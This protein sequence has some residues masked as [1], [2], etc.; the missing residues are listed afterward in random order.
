[1]RLERLELK[2]FMRFGAAVSLDL[3]DVPTGVIAVT[4][5]NGAGK[6]TILDSG[7]AAPFLAFPSRE[8]GLADYAT[9]RDAYLDVLYSVEG[10]GVYR[11]RVNVD[12]MKRAS[13]AVLELVHPDGTRTPLNDGKV[14]T[15]REK[16][17]EIFPPK[18]LLLAS[19]FAA[20]N[21]AGSFVTLDKKGRKDLFAALLGLKHYEQ[22]ADT[23]K[24]CVQVV[25][26][27]RLQLQTERDLLARDTTP[28][29]Q[30]DLHVRANA[31]QGEGGQAELRRDELRTLIDRLTSER[32]VLVDQAQAHLAALE[33]VQAL[34]KA[35]GLHKTELE[36]IERDQERARQDAASESGRA[37]GHRDATL[38]D[39]TRRESSELARHGAAVSDLDQRLAG[40]RTLLGRADEIRKAAAT[41]AEAQVAIQS[42]RERE[43]LARA[44]ETAARDQVQFRERKLREIE[45]AEH[46]LARARRQ[47]ETLRTVP[48]GG[49]GEY[50]AC[51]FLTDTQAAQARIPELEG[52]VATASTLRDGV[53][54]WNARIDD[55]HTRIRMA[56]S[57]IADQEQLIAAH[58]PNAKYAAHIDAAEARIAEYEQAKTAAEADLQARLRDLEAERKQAQQRYLDITRDIDARLEARIAALIDRHGRVRRAM[59]EAEADLVEAK[60][61]DQATRQAA[62]RLLA[63]DAELAQARHDWTANESVLAAVAA[64]RTELEREREAFA[65][66]ARH[67]SDVQ[68][69]LRVLDDELLAWQL[70]TKAFG[71]DGLPTLEID[72]AGPTVSNLTNDLLSACFG[73]RFTVDLVT[74]EARADGKGLKEIFSIFVFDN[75]FGG[76]QRDIA[77]LSGGE[78]VIV[79][80]ALRAALALFVNSRN[81]MPIRTL[82]R[83]E[84]VGALDPENA[85]RYVS[86]LR[87]LQDLGGYAHILFISHNL[88]A[89]ALADT[90]IRVHDGQLDVVRRAA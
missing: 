70:L 79:E 6:T 8:G 10:R 9:E 37:E 66:K 12:G 17:A 32:D 15:F 88:D 41:V 50:A 30:H 3:R 33:R 11:A 1:M 36:Q 2:G 14:T 75:Q 4:G 84:T 74:Q 25:E 83:D 90:E 81:E 29:I 26:S 63:I 34:A 16:V 65:R 73:P 27:G 48:C 80:E 40:N 55:A 23:A 5:E 13:D 64:K 20:Q 42:L 78:R 54:H 86:M 53:A 60:A 57:A 43:Q 52:L 59:S 62:D 39:L 77:D 44:D 22:M 49:A 47:V 61:V 76:D 72:A 19:A 58:T 89:A 35:L 82:W 67:L 51:R 24:R 31:L 38:V 87:R 28:A 45:S 18:E 56:L 21:K 46:D 69:R 85:I 68:G 7:L 71:R